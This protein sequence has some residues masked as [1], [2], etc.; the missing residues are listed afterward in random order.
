ML[1]YE[2]F[3]TILSMLHA[4]S[5]VKV[6]EL[7]EMLDVSESTIRRD[8]SD[9]ADSGRLKKVFG[10]A[11]LSTQDRTATL[12][13]MKTKSVTH[14]E[15]KKIIARY[16]ASLIKDNEF[17]F[18]DAG[19]TTGAMIPYLTNKTVTYVTNGARHALQLAAK[20]LPTYIISGQMRETTESIVGPVAVEGIQ[21]YNFTKCFM[22]TDA[23]DLDHGFTTSDIDEALIKTE[24]IRKGNQIFILAD[25][26]K[27]DMVA[28]VF[29]AGLDAGQIVTDEL[30]EKEY[31]KITDVKE[32]KE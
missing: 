7:A 22:G 32:V 23:I 14:I 29:F 13:D 28:P 10:G 8:I 26:S 20:G 19:S 25:H 21:K 4:N 3:E 12:M 24:A 1:Q 30:P 11:V 17:V 6:S 5:T 15:E 31:R 2:R 16:A 9:L 18:I 27:F